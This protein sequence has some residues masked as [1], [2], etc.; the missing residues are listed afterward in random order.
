MW[1]L[2]VSQP[3]VCGAGG[4]CWGMDLNILYVYVLHKMWGSF[5]QGLGV[6]RLV[7]ATGKSL[8]NLI[9]LN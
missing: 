6:M 8:S 2:A 5:F 7:V 4:W 3:Y 9:L 1:K